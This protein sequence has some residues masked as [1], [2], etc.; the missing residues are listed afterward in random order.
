MVTVIVIPPQPDFSFLLSGS[1]RI[2]QAGESRTFTLAMTSVDYFKGQLFLFASSRLGFEEVFS[3]PTIALDFGN[4]STS[5]MTLT[6]DANSEPGNRNVTLTAHWHY[7][8]RCQ[9]DAYYRSNADYY[10]R[11]IFEYNSWVN[12]FDLL[13]RGRRWS[14]LSSYYSVRR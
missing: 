14:A 10:S 12:V 8:H 3:P 4:S 2:I 11:P 6:T 1:G 7:I 13:G 9:C 5:T